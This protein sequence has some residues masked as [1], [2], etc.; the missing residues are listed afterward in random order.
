MNVSISPFH[1]AIPVTDLEDARQFYVTILGCSIGRFSE[2]WIDYDFFGHQLT[3]H[4]VT[5]T[6]EDIQSNEVDGEQVPVRHFGII[7]EWENW[8]SLRDELLDRQVKFLIQ[9]TTRFKDQPG[10]QTTMFITDPSGNAL[11]FKSFRDQR[12][13]FS[14]I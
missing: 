14:S 12:S 4:L 6:S 9:P 13:I 10:E 5:D 1:L 7:L 11:E 3:T 2:K 8:H